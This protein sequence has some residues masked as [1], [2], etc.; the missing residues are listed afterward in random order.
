MSRLTEQSIM[1]IVNNRGLK[2]VSKGKRLEKGFFEKI[3]IAYK[4]ISS[5]EGFEHIE[6]FGEFEEIKQSVALFIDIR[7]STERFKIIGPYKSYVTIETFLP[8]M[9]QLVA[10]FGGTIVQFTGD[11]IFALFFKGYQPYTRACYCAGYMMIA[12]Y[13]II[14][15]FFKN[16]LEGII[17]DIPQIECG[18]G[19]D[20][21]DCFVLKTG[22]DR[23]PVI[24]PYGNCINNAAHLSNGKGEAILSEDL[25]E[26]VKSMSKV[27]F[28]V[29]NNLQWTIKWKDMK[30]PTPDYD[31]ISKK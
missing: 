29:N 7:K 20:I 18:I 28:I 22:S 25:Y 19:L 16:F 10:F 24:T 11:G 14:N 30:F 21:G 6:D 17:I 15:V 13:D 9:A 8:T 1:I 26:W 23:F 12:V 27:S 4:P 5:L 3:A 2:A 31:F